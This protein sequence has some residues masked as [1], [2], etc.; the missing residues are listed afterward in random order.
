LADSIRGH[1]DLEGED[2][3][4]A[5]RQAAARTYRQAGHP[6]QADRLLQE[7]HVLEAAIGQVVAYP[8]WAVRP[9]Q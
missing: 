9:V 8:T 4:G 1:V 7:A 3:P 5:E 6:D 2:L